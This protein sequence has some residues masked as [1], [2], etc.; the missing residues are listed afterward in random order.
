MIPSGTTVT[1]PLTWSQIVPSGSAANVTVPITLPAIS[2]T[3]LNT[4]TVN[5][6][7]S[8]SVPTD[9]D[10]SKCTGSATT[11]TAAAGHACIYINDPTGDVASVLGASLAYR[12]QQGFGI[13]LAIGATGGLTEV[14]GAW[15]YHAP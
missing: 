3:I 13:K 12:K 4:S 8:G 5:V 2:P 15:A 7:S 11:P 9:G 10:P 1:G 6:V 14:H